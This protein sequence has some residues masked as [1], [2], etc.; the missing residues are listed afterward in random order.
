M[1]SIDSAETEYR[2]AM[3]LTE[4]KHG[5]GTSKEASVRANLAMVMAARSKY[6]EALAEVGHAIDIYTRLA[7]ADSPLTLH[8]KINQGAYLFHLGRYRDAQALLADVVSK[9]RSLFGADS[10]IVAGTLLNL[11]LANTE[12]PDLDAAEQ[13]FTESADVFEKKY[14]REHP[15]ARA[16]QND[17]AYV[18]LLKGEL[19]RADRE[20]TQIDV[21][22]RQR[23]ESDDAAAL[24]WWGEHHA[25]RGDVTMAQTLERRAL[26]AAQTNF[27]EKSR[28]AA[29]AHYYLALTLRD[30]GDAAGAITELRASLESFAG[31]IPN[32]DHPMAA[33]AR[34][35]LADL[36]ERE[37]KIAGRGASVSAGGRGHTATVP[38]QRR[39]TYRTSV[40][41]SRQIGD[42]TLMNSSK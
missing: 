38:G 37:P 9:Q 34:L 24:Y 29:V 11:G 16:A 1:H 31:Y 6:P 39:S 25:R 20:F 13:A 30:N 23:H 15:G 18:H 27:G 4:L 14:G 32:A 19:D 33:T 36:L 10:T 35:M 26:A 12:V 41:R 3:Q 2:E 21:L 42:A 7:G 5:A 17:L 40:G 8:V 28:Y 22:N